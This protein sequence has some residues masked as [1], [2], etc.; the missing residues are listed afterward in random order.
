[1]K[2]KILSEF[3]FSL[4]QKG[5]STIINSDHINALILTEKKQPCQSID[6]WTPLRDQIS[7]ASIINF[8]D[9]MRLRGYLMTYE[10]TGKGGKRPV[11]QIRGGTLESLINQIKQDFIKHIEAEL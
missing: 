1:M 7:R 4:D 5:L 9:D 11:Y 3:K 2:Q 10:E 6:I 8:L